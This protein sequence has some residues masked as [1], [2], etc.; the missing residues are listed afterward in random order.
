MAW[1]LT[2]ELEPITVITLWIQELLQK[3]E[4]VLGYLASR[5]WSLLEYWWENE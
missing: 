5:D 3:I 4:R 2:V 1:V